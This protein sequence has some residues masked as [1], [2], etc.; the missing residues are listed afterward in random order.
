MFW[1]SERKQDNSHKWFIDQHQQIYSWHACF[2]SDKGTFLWLSLRVLPWVSFTVTLLRLYMPKDSPTQS[3][4]TT[5]PRIHWP[6]GNFQNLMVVFPVS[7]PPRSRLVT[8]LGPR[9]GQGMLSTELAGI[10]VSG[11]CSQRR[12]M[13][14]GLCRAEFHPL[15]T[16][17]L[18]TLTFDFFSWLLKCIC[19]E[20]STWCFIWLIIWSVII[21][22]LCIFRHRILWL[23][24]TRDT[25]SA[26]VGRGSS[27]SSARSRRAASACQVIPLLPACYTCLVFLLSPQS[28]TSRAATFHQDSILLNSW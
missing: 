10:L 4:L 20:K 6:R 13:F 26:V 15:E 7:I 19:Q 22:R 21:Y 2:D 12:G 27:D 17:K 3:L 9:E 24:C 8:S 28:L 14:S 18:K 1:Y 23:H 11:S 16:R 25:S 5:L